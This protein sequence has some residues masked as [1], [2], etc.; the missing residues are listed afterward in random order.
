MVSVFV[1]EGGRRARK[2]VVGSWRARLLCGNGVS[3]SIGKGGVS[4]V[5]VVVVVFSWILLCSV[6]SKKGW[7]VVQYGSGLYFA[8]LFSNCFISSSSPGWISRAYVKWMILQR[9]VEAGV[10]REVVS[11]FWGSGH[12]GL[13]AFIQASGQGQWNLGLSRLRCLCSLITP[14]N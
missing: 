3:I 4:S 2:V 6:D 1:V 8:A 11:T 12:G 9:T 13:T 10:V 5:V 7:I 14:Y